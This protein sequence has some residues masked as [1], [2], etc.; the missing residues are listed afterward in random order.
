MNGKSS[1]EF[2]VT[3]VGGIAI[4]ILP[5]LVAYGVLTSELA[6]VW[7]GVITAIVT[8]VVPPVLGSMAKAYTAARTEVKVEAMAVERESMALEAL[9]LEVMESLAD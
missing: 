2:W 8:I 5:L 4:A 3:T 1:T 9:R 6:D 7:K